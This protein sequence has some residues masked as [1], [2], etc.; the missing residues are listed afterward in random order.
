M[1]LWVKS[2]LTPQEIRDR[3]MSSDSEFQRR[4]VEYLEGV[5][6][7]EFLSS[8]VDEV[9]ER[10]D[11]MHVDDEHPTAVE[12]MAVP[13]PTCVSDNSCNTKSECGKCLSW[14]EQFVNTVN[15]LLF[16]CNTHR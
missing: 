7:G 5:H 15:E 11:Y 2:A 4:L 1:L 12:T 13:P 14:K 6:N 8:S 10:L 3:L 16:R 9:K